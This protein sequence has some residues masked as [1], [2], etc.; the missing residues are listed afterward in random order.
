MSAV[1]RRTLFRILGGVAVLLGGIG[2]L[3]P[4]MPTTVFLIVASWAFAKSSPRLSAWLDRS[5]LGTP[6]R[7]FRD[8]GAMPRRAKVAALLS[9]AAGVSVGAW[10]TSAHGPVVPVL[11]VALGLVGAWTVAFRVPTAEAEWA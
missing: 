4:G 7:R 1:L 10:G 3:V 2:V 6:L 11:V 9:M 8:T 5:R